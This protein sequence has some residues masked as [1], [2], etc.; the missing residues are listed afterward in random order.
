[1]AEDWPYLFKVRNGNIINDE[2]SGISAP[3]HDTR[4]VKTEVDDLGE[5]VDHPFFL[6]C[7]QESLA[8][9]PGTIS[10]AGAIGADGDKLGNFFV[11]RPAFVSEHNEP[12]PS[13]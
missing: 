1:M 10:H 3:R 11:L 9:V 5:A 2:F 7:N 8:F 13:L 12:F 6:T 4:T